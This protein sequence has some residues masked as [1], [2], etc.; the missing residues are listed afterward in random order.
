[1]KLER[2]DSLGCSLRYILPV[3]KHIRSVFMRACFL[4]LFF[5]LKIE[6]YRAKYILSLQP[7]T[8][9]VDYIDFFSLPISITIIC[10][11]K[12]ALHSSALFLESQIFLLSP[13]HVP[14]AA[15]LKLYILIFPNAIL[16]TN[17]SFLQ[18]WSSDFPSSFSPT[19]E[20]TRQGDLREGGVK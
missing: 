18:A 10:I 6:H 2:E 5:H 1:M 20:I 4:F 3:R 14:A 15:I 16:L 11:F 19:G 8:G 17:F 12:V 13:W 7:F 9:V